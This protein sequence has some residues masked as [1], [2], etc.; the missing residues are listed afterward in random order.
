MKINSTDF[1]VR[2]GDEV[3]LKRWSTIVDPVYGSKQRYQA[4]LSEHVARL[5]ALQQL[6]YA[7][8]AEQR[9]HP[10]DRVAHR[11][12][13]PRRTQNDLPGNSAERRQ[14]LLSIRERLA[15]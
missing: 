7:S 8:N 11:T 6:L 2:A 15:K 10:A 4:L 9:K 3:N 14:E 5:S 1:Q 13:Y 12:R